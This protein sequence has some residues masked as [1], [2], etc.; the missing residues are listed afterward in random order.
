MYGPPCTSPSTKNRAPS[1]AEEVALYNRQSLRH[2]S[3]GPYCQPPLKYAASIRVVCIPTNKFEGG[4][5]TENARPIPG[6]IHRIRYTSVQSSG[7][8]SQV[9]RSRP[10]LA[11]NRTTGMPFWVVWLQAGGAAGAPAITVL[12]PSVRFGHNPG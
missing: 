4:Y 9:L 1:A 12:S 7:A 2:R 6:P 11:R 5:C 10:S 3:T 8:P